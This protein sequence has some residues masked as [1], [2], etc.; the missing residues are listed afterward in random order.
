MESKFD[1]RIIA[2]FNRGLDERIREALNRLEHLP[3]NKNDQL[4]SE[5][6][7]DVLGHRPMRSFRDIENQI[8]IQPAST[9]IEHVL[10]ALAR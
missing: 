10:D 6:I 8:I 5:V 9:T 4:L 7:G 3:A 1:A 2:T